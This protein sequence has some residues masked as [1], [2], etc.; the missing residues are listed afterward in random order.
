M[1]KFRTKFRN[2]FFPPEGSPRKL[3]ILPYAILGILTIALLYGGAYGWEY[4]NSPQFCG[5]TC[6]TMPPQNATYQISPHANVYCT[7]CHIG[8]AFVGQQ[9]A[10][11]TEDIY[12]LY[13]TVLHLYEFPIRA[14]RSKPDILTCE[15]CH[16]PETFSDDS[17]RTISHFANDAQNS[18]S[19]TYLILKTGGG[20]KREGLGRGIH[21]HIVNPV[22]YYAEDPENQVIPYVRVQND[23][24]SYTEYVDVGSGFDPASVDESKLKQMECTTCHNRVSHNFQPPEV[25]INSAMD[26]GLISSEIPGIH[27]RALDALSAT[28]ATRDEAM[29]AFD[30]IG[31]HYKNTEFYPGHGE[32]ISQ[33]VQTIKDIYDQ[34][35]FLEQKVDWTTHPNNIGHIYSPGCFRCH[36]GK[37]LDADNQA[38]R[39]ECNVCHSIPVVAGAQDF[40]TNI[41]ISR[42]PEPESHLNP[43]WIA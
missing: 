24:G 5:T 15:K 11:K 3:L 19:T 27:K 31:E 43:N 35:V 38:I 8:R 23:D 34:T 42:G 26:R 20:S 10:R 7:E 30:A 18:K 41:E 22:Y 33:A 13:S 39:L 28:Y 1:T 6:H 40:V 29:A 36:D 16:L 25:S 32:Q 21:W 37:H 9:L 2:F 14:T 12:E 4:T 17:L